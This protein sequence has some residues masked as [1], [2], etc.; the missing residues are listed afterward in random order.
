MKV[1]SRPREL[2][3]PDAHLDVAL[4]PN[5]SPVGDVHVFKLVHASAQ[6]AAHAGRVRQ[7]K[8]A[9]GHSQFAAD[10]AAQVGIAVPAVLHQN[11]VGINRH[12]VE[13]RV[14]RSTCAL[15]IQ[16]NRQTRQMVRLSAGRRGP[17]RSGRRGTPPRRPRR[18][19][20][21]R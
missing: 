19:C 17:R 12:A 13:R 14:Q 1:E 21:R 18:G 4:A 5:G 11:R 20:R 7:R 6:V 16:R 15:V 2:A 8:A 9:S 10:A 3:L